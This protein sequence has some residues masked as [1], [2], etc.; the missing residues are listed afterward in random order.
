[1]ST[2][3]KLSDTYYQLFK[4]FESLEQARLVAGS[5]FGEN[6][7]GCFQWFLSPSAVIYL[8]KRNF[9]FWNELKGNRK[10]IYQLEP[11]Q[12]F[13]TEGANISLK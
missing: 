7:G 8:E 13:Q 9:D 4:L 2:N 12:G 5:D 3:I 11:W 10:I 6:L 1:M